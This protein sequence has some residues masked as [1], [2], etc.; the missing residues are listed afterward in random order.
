MSIQNYSEELR[1]FISS[2]SIFINDESFQTREELKE[3]PEIIEDYIEKELSSE[4]ISCLFFYL[5]YLIQDQTFL[6]EIIERINKKFF[7]KKI[8]AKEMPDIH[9]LIVYKISEEKFLEENLNKIKNFFEDYLKQLKQAEELE[10]EKKR[11]EE[12][13]RIKEQKEKEKRERFI[14]PKINNFELLELKESH[15]NI[16]SKEIKFLQFNTNEYNIDK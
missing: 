3:N 9:Y 14:L 6:N 2:N 16:I 4:K 13:Q 1:N 5:S 11:L 7:D 12:E 8:K 10:K 15:V